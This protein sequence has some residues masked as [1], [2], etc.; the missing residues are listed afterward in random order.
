MKKIIIRNIV[1]TMGVVISSGCAITPVAFT[2]DEMVSKAKADLDHLEGQYIPV[3]RPISLY[4]AMARSLAYNLDLRLE[5]TEKVLAQRELTLTKYDQL[6]EFVTNLDYSG[7]SNF[8]GASSRSLDTGL[9]SLES[10]TSADRYIASSE[11]QLSWNILDFGVSYIRAQ[12]SADQVLIAEEQR[13]KVVNDLIKNV[14]SLYWRAVSHDRLEKNLSD[15]LER[16]DDALERSRK[17][18][19]DR[20]E[21][22]LV[23]LTY[24]RELMD[25]RRR[26]LELQRELSLTK[27][28]LAALMNLHPTTE[29]ELV[30]PDRTDALGDLDLTPE[31]MEELSL[32]NRSE[33]R[34]VGYRQRINAKETK[35]AI[36]QLL[37]GLDFNIGVSQSDN[38]FLENK[39]WTSF[40]SII[41]WNLFNAF[42][43][44]DTKRVFEQRDE[45][46]NARRLALSMAVLTQVH[47]S[48]AQLEFSKR[49]YQ[50]WSNYYKTQS[51]I[52]DQ[53]Y[54]ASKTRSIR[55][56]EVIQEEMS[57]LIAEVRYDI[58]Y[59]DLQNAYAD[60]YAAIGVD[61]IP[62]DIEKHDVRDLTTAL[63]NHF[64]QML[65]DGLDHK[66]NMSS[67][68]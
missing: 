20:L 1:L 33:L 25:V 67:E 64:E 52:L 7:R 50:S 40:G 3:T 29:Y 19:K 44:P 49:E 46:L 6:P 37:P 22:P 11:Y 57:T 36:L 45:V 15:I 43:I 65:N 4:E 51:M 54:A 56:R 30:I 34:E 9:E 14:R 26:L 17:V 55:E 59:A 16:V 5:A 41:S 58:A 68:I 2:T 61:D 21:T 48:R 47:V 13:R 8:S 60:I 35:A 66:D 28:Q 62:E 42:K 27:I 32:V 24:Q 31:M 63:E 12:Q 23:V 53:I 38:S 10:S 18:E 39:D